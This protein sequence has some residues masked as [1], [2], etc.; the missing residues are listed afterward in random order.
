LGRRTG[1]IRISLKVVSGAAR[2]RV[3]ITAESIERAVDLARAR[4]PG[5]MVEVSFPIDPEAFFA[6]KTFTGGQIWA[7]AELSSAGAEERATLASNWV[8]AAEECV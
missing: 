1:V 7:E 4:Y 5:S 8:D 3:L 2:S 6:G